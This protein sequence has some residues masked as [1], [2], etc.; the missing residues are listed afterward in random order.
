[1]KL[2][3]AG[4]KPDKTRVTTWI[5][6]LLI[7]QLRAYAALHG[8]TVSQA[9]EKLIEQEVTSKMRIEVAVDTS[10]KKMMH[11]K[12]HFSPLDKI[13]AEALREHREGKTTIIDTPE[14]LKV[15]LRKL[16]ESV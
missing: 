16:Q 8:I 10:T 7:S 3:D 1:M 9:V 12:K 14:K 5:D 13:A 11:V 2:K 6:P 4:Y 15:Y